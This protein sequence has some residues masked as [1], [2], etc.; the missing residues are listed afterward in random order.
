MT[1]TA[2]DR[3]PHYS[4][5]RAGQSNGPEKLQLWRCDEC[6]ALLY[7]VD[8]PEVKGVRV[9]RKLPVTE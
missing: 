3:C 1:A 8:D 9:A 5:T 2:M 4:A 6:G 7:E